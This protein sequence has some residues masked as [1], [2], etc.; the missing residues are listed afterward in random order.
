MHSNV[1]PLL[2][3]IALG[4]AASAQQVVLCINGT[5][6]TLAAFDPVTG[7]LITP[8]FFAIP[9]TTSVGVA[10]VNG[11]LWVTEQVLDR[12]TRYD[13]AGVVLGTIGPTFAGGGFD[14]IRGLGVANGLVYVSNA[15]ANNGA[16]ANSVVIL[17]LAGNH[18]STFSVNALAT[19]PFS[20]VGHQG[21]VLVAGFSNNQDVYR[22]TATGTP[23][24]VFHDSTTIN[25]AH[26]LAPAIDGNVWCSSF[27]DDWL[28][29]LD[30][31]TGA[32][33]QQIPGGSTTRGVWQVA[34]GNVLWSD[35]AGV[36]LF[37]QVTQTSS[38]LLA[39]SC[40]HFCVY[41][42]A[43]GTASATPFGT[44]CDGLVLATNGL[45]QLGNAT[46]AL[47]LNN[48]PAVSPVGLFAFGS[49]V[50]NPGVDLTVVGMPGCFGYSS[51]DIGLF[52]GGL[53]AS[54]TS[55]FPL[56]I[57]VVPAL[58]GTA[59]ATQG[60]SFSLQTPLGLAASNGNA[61]LLGN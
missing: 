50:V 4:A 61:L 52:T 46:F 47:L 19:S 40:Y 6:D 17:D 27:T 34:N 5:S 57:P 1:L 26:G 7:S 48:V 30:A 60:L 45:P 39:G 21:D 28:C 38:L 13:A 3:A 25:P 55:S 49:T 20:I 2:A 22:F 42:T 18:V 43:A 10:D 32:I 35:G 23:V 24:G 33:L 41:G 44:G 8:S 16:T 54:G 58:V 14:N 31:T 59:L 29:K 36:H 9:N 53:V 12:I 51:L 37:D 11:E 56:P 15:G